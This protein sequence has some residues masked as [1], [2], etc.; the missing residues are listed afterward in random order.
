MLS[1]SQRIFLKLGNR[2]RFKDKGVTISFDDAKKQIKERMNRNK[3]VVT[4]V[5]PQEELIS[6]A[7]H[8]E[9]IG[10]PERIVGADG[11]PRLFM[12]KK[13]VNLGYGWITAELT[14]NEV[15]VMLTEG[16]YTLAPA[17]TTEHRDEEHFKSHQLALVDIDKGM[18][19][20][21]LKTLEFYQQYGS[22]FYT[23]PSHTAQDHRFRI[24]YKLDTA[25]TDPQ[26]M[27]ELYEGLLVI[28][29]A[30]DISCK[31]SARL[32]FG[33]VDA[34]Q[35]EITTRTLSSVGLQQAIDAREKFLAAKNASIPVS[36]RDKFDAP[37]EQDVI[38]ILDELRKLY[39]DFNYSTRFA[40]TRAVA[41]AI[42]TSLA[43]YH[44]RTR[45]DDSSKTAKYE[46]LLKDPLIAGGPTLGTLVHMIRDKDSTFRKKREVQKAEI[47]ESITAKKK[48]KQETK[49]KHGEF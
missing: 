27:R 43:V 19:I 36:N 6:F 11:I 44:M 24:I 33:T 26:K 16:G 30:A 17:L 42:G 2:D 40:V 39:S 21:Q 35:K 28:H 48:L 49:T 7:Y 12:G 47:I 37:N 25:I 14:F 41:S 10:K 9:I 4:I 1:D 13:Q 3:D 22:G 31:D 23:T 34:V 18:Q 15:F 5:T 20:N 8:K 38:E 45:W 46:D 29:G 32:F